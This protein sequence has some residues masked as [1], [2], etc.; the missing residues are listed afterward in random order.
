MHTSETALIAINMLHI[1]MDMFV[2]NLPDLRAAFSSAI[3]SLL[4]HFLLLAFM[5][6]CQFPI[7]LLN[8]LCHFILSCL[9]S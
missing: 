8:L 5:T 4:K 3:P 6:L 7:N 1:P 2:I 9:T